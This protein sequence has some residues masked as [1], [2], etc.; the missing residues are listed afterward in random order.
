MRQCSHNFVKKLCFFVLGF[1]SEISPTYV[2][3]FSHKLSVSLYP[4]WVR[5]DHSVEMFFVLGDVYANRLPFLSDE[6]RQLSETLMKFW[7]NFARSGY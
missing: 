6:E 5:A 4:D 1:F 3:K 7:A 2:Y